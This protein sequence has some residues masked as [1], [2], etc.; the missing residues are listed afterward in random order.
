MN[1]S[2]GRTTSPEGVE[3]RTHP[4]RRRDQPQRNQPTRNGAKEHGRPASRLSDCGRPSPLER[5]VLSRQK[6]HSRRPRIHATPT[7]LDLYPIPAVLAACVIGHQ[8]GPFVIRRRPKADRSVLAQELARARRRPFE[9]RS[10]TISSNSAPVDTKPGAS[11]AGI[12]ALS[13]GAAPFHLAS[14]THRRNVGNG[15][16]NTSRFTNYELRGPPWI[17]VELLSL[18]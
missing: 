1:A 5:E 16:A 13:A 3:R 10:G 8:A 7:G 9:L 6:G 18:P 14:S 15:S 12:A 4:R 2:V 17:R 11:D